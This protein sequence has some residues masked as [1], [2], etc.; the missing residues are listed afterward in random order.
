MSDIDPRSVG[1]AVAQRA[2]FLEPLIM[3]AGKTLASYE[4]VYETYGALNADRSN[5]VLV[6][7]A[8]S[9]SHHVAGFYADDP[10]KLGWWDNLI[11]PGKPI[12]TDRFFVIGVNNLGGCHGST[13]P[14][15]I[16]RATGQPYGAAFPVVTVEDWVVSQARLMDRLGIE[17]LGAA[18]AGA[19]RALRVRGMKDCFLRRPTPAYRINARCRR[20]TH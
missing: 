17:K 18:I 4:L 2:G 7:H 15:S 9:G 3:K 20:S 5:A 12:D 1:A 16:D 8:L 14:G 11:G 19:P 10:K 13:G 6:C